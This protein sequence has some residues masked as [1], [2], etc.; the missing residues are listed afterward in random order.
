[1]IAIKIHNIYLVGSGSICSF[2]QYLISWLTDKSYPFY[3]SLMVVDPFKPERGVFS[4]QFDIP[5]ECSCSVTKPDDPL[6]FL[7][8]GDQSGRS[9]G[10]KYTTKSDAGESTYKPEGPLGGIW[11]H[12][13]ISEMDIESRNIITVQWAI[14]TPEVLR[15]TDSAKFANLTPLMWWHIFLQEETLGFMLWIR[16]RRHLLQFLWSLIFTVHSLLNRLKLTIFFVSQCCT[17]LRNIFDMSLWT[18]SSLSLN[19]IVL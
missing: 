13:H 14:V 7:E 8:T 11:V 15:S 3:S 10:F 16:P 6:P 2:G 12:S 19:E 1:M 17:F 18:F 5:T 9:D 4:A